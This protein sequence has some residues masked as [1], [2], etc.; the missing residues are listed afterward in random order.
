MVE[1]VN[2]AVSQIEAQ[3]GAFPQLFGYQWTL[4]SEDWST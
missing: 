1:G 4:A 2:K 3:L